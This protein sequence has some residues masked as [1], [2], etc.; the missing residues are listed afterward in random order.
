MS[1]HHDVYGVHEGRG[2]YGADPASIEL[3]HVFSKVMPLLPPD[4]PSWESTR[5]PFQSHPFPELMNQHWTF[6]ESSSGVS[7]AYAAVKN[8]K[9]VMLLAGVRGHVKLTT[10]KDVSYKAISLKDGQTVYSG[11][12]H[13]VVLPQSEGEAYLVL[14][15]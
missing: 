15:T 1:A 4:L 6:G 14:S 7:R 13:D 2:E 10:E 8:E 12:G 5:V 3:Q 9:F 11:R